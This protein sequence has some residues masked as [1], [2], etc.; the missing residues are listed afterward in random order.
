MGLGSTSIERLRQE[1][2]DALSDVGEEFGGAFLVGSIR[3]TE[4]SAK[5]QLSFSLRDSSGVLLTREREDFIRVGWQYGME[6]E[7]LDEEA[8]IGGRLMKIV[9]LK[10]SR[11]KYPISCVD[12][13]GRSFKCD[14][15]SVQNAM[16]SRSRL[17]E[18]G[19]TLGNDD[20]L[21][22]VRARLEKEDGDGRDGSTG[23]TSDDSQRYAGHHGTEVPAG[24]A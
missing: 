15:A 5:I 21:A 11:H 2:N 6:P 23:G 7:W 4:N 18:S 13:A 20:P 9:G 22:Q 10:T 16:R 24:A 3:Y 12:R 1:I 19:E 8:L 14:S 17:G